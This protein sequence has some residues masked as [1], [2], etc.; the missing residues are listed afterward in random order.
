MSAYLEGISGEYA[1]QH[2]PVTSHHVRIGRGQGNQVLLR[3][4]K[5]SRSHAIVFYANGVYSVRDE[6]SHHGTKV[7]GTPVQISQ[8]REGDIIDVV[9]NTFRF[10]GSGGRQPAVSGGGYRRNEMDR[11]T[12]GGTIGTKSYVGDAFIV[13]GLYYV[14]LWIGGFI[15]N[16]IRVSEVNRIKQ[17][18][19]VEPEGSGC[20][21][22][23]LVVH[24]IL[25]IIV[26]L[27]G[28]AI[29][30]AVLGVLGLD[31]LFGW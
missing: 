16:I 28:G 15:F 10:H 11:R 20:L 24:I 17:E 2:V 27:S 4:N 3:S 29:L 13:L 31:M 14:G 7:N 21:W 22:A 5:V 9:G 26:V 19:G 12:P 30:S 1:G 6:N 23:L 8:L 18:T 25:P